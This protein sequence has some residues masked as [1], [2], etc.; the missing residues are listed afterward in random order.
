MRVRTREN[1]QSN[2]FYPPKLIFANQQDTAIITAMHGRSFLH[3]K[4]TI[5]QSMLHTYSIIE[6]VRAYYTTEACAC[7]FTIYESLTT[8]GAYCNADED[9]NRQNGSSDNRKCESSSRLQW[10][11]LK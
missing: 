10:I 4:R 5:L 6:N 3:P 7:N 8:S 1:Y 11:D 2:V 9:I